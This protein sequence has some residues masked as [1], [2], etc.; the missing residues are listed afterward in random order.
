M[1][2]ALFWLTLLIQYSYQDS[3]LE[4]KTIFPGE[5]VYISGE[6][7]GEKLTRFQIVNYPKVFPFEPIWRPL[8]FSADQLSGIPTFV[9]KKGTRWL[10]EL[11][12]NKTQLAWLLAEAGKKGLSCRIPKPIA[13]LEP[14]SIVQEFEREGVDDGIEVSYGQTV[15]L[16]GT[17]E[18]GKP[19][20]L[21]FRLT[22]KPYRMG[23]PIL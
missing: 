23:D 10:S 14:A 2:F 21:R 16:K 8:V 20:R 22:Q 7:T 18:G 6:M 9:D 13:T 17:L 5:E 11:P 1:N 15:E 4:C 12:L 19:F 3:T